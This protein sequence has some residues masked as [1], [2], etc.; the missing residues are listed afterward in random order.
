MRKKILLTAALISMS[1]SG[2][3]SKPAST[4]NAAVESLNAQ[5]TALQKENE[6]LK[7]QLGA[8][9]EA[10]AEETQAAPA[11][12]TVAVGDT[13]TTDSMEI[14][15]NNVELSYDVLPDNTSGVYT[16]YAAD[17]GNVYLHVDADVKNLGK[18]NLPCDEILKATADYNGGYTYKG[19][20]IPEDSNTGFTYA[21]IT[22]I[23]PLETLGV[24]FLFKCP[25]EVEETENPLFI[26]INPN[27]TKDIYTLIVR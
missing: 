19:Q 16:H 18:Q 6:D 2:C 21:N 23:K 27:G 24:H 15:I 17:S 8:T 10:A 5:I 11:R 9:A 26:T 12:T 14:T 13:I 1:L 20:A 22:A 25:Q 7:A 4:D 3:A